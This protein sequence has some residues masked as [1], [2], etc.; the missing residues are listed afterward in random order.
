MSNAL[1]PEALG[2]AIMAALRPFIKARQVPAPK[3]R[4]VKPA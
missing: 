4:P 2:D 1:T 3:R